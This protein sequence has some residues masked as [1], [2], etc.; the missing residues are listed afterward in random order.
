MR[1]LPTSF[2][3]VNIQNL[4]TKTETGEMGMFMKQLDKINFLRDQCKDENPYF[5]AL[6]ETWIKDGILES[7][8]TIYGYEHVASHRKSR[9]GGGVIIYI[10][11]DITYNF[12]TAASDEMCSLVAVHLTKLNLIIFLAYRPPPN[13]KNDYHGDTLERSFKNI[14][15]DNICKE[16]NKHKSPTPDIL[17]IG[18]FNFPKAQ[19][20]AGIGVVKPDNKC[21]RNSLQQLINIASEYSLLQYISEGTRE[22]RKGGNNILELIFTNNHELITNIHLQPSE[23]T[24]HKFIVCDTSYNLPINVTQHMSENNTNLSSYNYETANWKNIKASL[25]KINWSEIL[26]KHNSSEEK[27]RVVL[28]IVVKIIEENCTMFKSHG[29]PQLNKIPRDRRILLRKKKKLKLKLQNNNL[30]NDRKTQLE[31]TIRE[32]DKKLLDSHKEEKIVKETHAVRILNQ[33]IIKARGLP[34]L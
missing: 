31:I 26:A 27:L 28:E 32:I 10:R 3:I 11:E 21:N 22:T 12:L 14:I 29:G 6:A 4:L 24:D 23:I 25:K 7:E 1:I 2:H 33:H 34:P 19:W 9:D 16:M 15:I 17:L 5:L 18:D 30:G 20:N 13:Y 8:Y